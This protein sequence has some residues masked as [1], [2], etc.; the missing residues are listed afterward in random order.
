MLLWRH[1]EPMA[2]ELVQR[3]ERLVD[4][5]KPFNPLRNLGYVDYGLTF[6][7]VFGA[8][9]T[10]TLDFLS[11]K[12]Q[13]REYVSWASAPSV[14]LDTSDFISWLKGYT[15][16]L[17]RQAELLRPARDKIIAGLLDGVRRRPFFDPATP[18]CL[19][20][21]VLAGQ[22]FGDL[23]RPESV[24]LCSHLLSQI[25]TG[26]AKTLAWL[27]LLANRPE[28]QAGIHEEL[29]RAL[30]REGNP[31]LNDRP[32]LPWPSAA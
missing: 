6:R 13:L 27:L 31:T 14:A 32:G 12:S 29:E 18:T 11:L 7:A 5:G 20:E 24:G 21:V 28:V 15:T 1:V 25:P 9:G 23:D 30:G 22:E 10:N 3:V 19:A 4:A 16:R 8:G 2:E 26:V 17:E